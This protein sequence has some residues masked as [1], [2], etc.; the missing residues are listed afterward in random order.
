[1]NSYN[2]VQQAVNEAKI[3]KSVLTIFALTNFVC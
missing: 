3:F 1:M 2:I